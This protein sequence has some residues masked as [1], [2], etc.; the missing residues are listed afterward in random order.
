[1][2]KCDQAVM[3]F[4]ASTK[5]GNFPLG[6]RNPWVFIAFFLFLCLGWS[7]YFILF[8]LFNEEEGV[9]SS[10]EGGESGTVIL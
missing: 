5:V 10:G 1:M 2:D 7:F 8:S 3:D 4:L 9:R 6:E